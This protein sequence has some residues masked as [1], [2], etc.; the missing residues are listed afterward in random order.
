VLARLLARLAFRKQAVRGLPEEEGRLAG[1]E[2]VQLRSRIKKML[3]PVSA[4]GEGVGR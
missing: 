2:V 3:A 4:D 1:L